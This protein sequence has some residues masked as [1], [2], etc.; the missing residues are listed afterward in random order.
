MWRH[1]VSLLTAVCSQKC[2]AEDVQPMGDE[3]MF[4]WISRVM[5]A[6][7]VAAV[8]LQ[9]RSIPQHGRRTER[10]SEW[11]PRRACGQI[12]LPRQPTGS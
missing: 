9:D 7:E 12:A 1:S 4:L 8:K 2:I 5:P 11:R 3:V 10:R 6:I